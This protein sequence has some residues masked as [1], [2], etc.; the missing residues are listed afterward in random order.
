MLNLLFHAKIE[1]KIAN[2]THINWITFNKIFTNT[3]HT[4]INRPTDDDN[5]KHSKLIN[6]LKN[7]ELDQFLPTFTT[8]YTCMQHCKIRAT[9]HKFHR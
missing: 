5:R 8:K 7:I 1:K 4:T 6:L 2:K 3:D 9:G